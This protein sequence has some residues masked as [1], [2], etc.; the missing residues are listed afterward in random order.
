MLWAGWYVLLVLFPVSILLLFMKDGLRHVQTVS[1]R[2][3]RRARRRA[4]YPAR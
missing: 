3:K 1:R 2:S 4:G